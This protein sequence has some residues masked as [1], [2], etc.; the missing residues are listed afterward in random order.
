MTLMLWRNSQNFNLKHIFLAHLLSLQL[1]YYLFVIFA[2]AQMPET[3]RLFFLNVDKSCNRGRQEHIKSKLHKKIRTNHSSYNEDYNV[4]IHCPRADKRIEKCK[5]AD[6]EYSRIN[7][8]GRNS[9]KQ[10][11]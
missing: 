5:A 1:F 9:R 7:D 8:R 3:L 6:E 11:C 4:S 2:Y 10:N